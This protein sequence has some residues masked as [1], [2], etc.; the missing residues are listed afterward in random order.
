V[1]SER[2]LNPNKGTARIVTD[3]RFTVPLHHHCATMTCDVLSFLS[4]DNWDLL[5]G[6][7]LY[8]P[9]I[10]KRVPYKKRGPAA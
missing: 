4:G 1:A 8:M 6:E 7:T 3:E 2:Y 9:K 10:A 5:C